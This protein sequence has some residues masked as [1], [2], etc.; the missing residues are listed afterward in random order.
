MAEPTV[1]APPH[2][3]APAGVA[4]VG[5][6]R[7]VVSDYSDLYVVARAGPG[8]SLS[9]LERPDGVARF[10]PSGMAY[11]SSSRLLYVANYTGGDVLVLEWRDDARPVLR[12]RLAGAGLV[13][14]EDVA[15]WQDGIVVADFDG[16]AVVAFD[17]R[18]RRIWS[19]PLNSAHG[20][21]VHGSTIY[22]TG[23]YDR[24]LV[25][26]AP[27]GHVVRKTGGLGQAPNRF[28]W[29]TGV[30]ALANGLLAV[31]DAHTGL[32]TLFDRRFR[33][34][35]AVG[36]NGPG[37][38]LF[39]YP[40]VLSPHGDGFAVAD[41]YGARLVLLD[42]AWRMTAQI[43]L[44]SPL[45][46][47]FGGAALVGQPRR[48]YVYP[49]L[50]AGD[51]GDVLSGT[52]AVGG[53]NALNAL[54]RGKRP[55]YQLKIGQPGIGYVYATWA[56]RTPLPGR[57]DAVLI[58]T[59][60]QPGAWLV[61]TP[62]GAWTH[63]MIGYDVWPSA[64]MPRRSGDVALDPDR[65]AYVAARFTELERRLAAGADRAAAFRE[66][67][68]GASDEEF[69]REI[70][71]ASEY[72][73]DFYEAV[74]SGGDRGRARARYRKS[75]RRSYGRHLFEALAVEYLGR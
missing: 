15:P 25:E 69:F 43:A 8:W 73:R 71:S 19:V 72:G 51:L 29:P 58:G 46:T 68:P 20:V 35:G 56:Q 59:P 3:V 64:D 16:D 7:F 11:D 14:P 22:A 61:D 37:V 74:T 13:G 32:I 55:A 4:T 54:G 67:I 70:L 57:D 75:A 5:R 21:T 50:H 40:Y 66:T 6:D 9:R 10:V 18:D 1:G 60:Q 33:V 12:R 47:R 28:L 48:P 45:A 27:N 53:Y 34:R 23:L 31:N 62:T 41:T 36:G 49:Q 2:G 44:A 63:V 52:R 39:N 65:W 30:T 42:G 17:G 38:D 26:I 24:I